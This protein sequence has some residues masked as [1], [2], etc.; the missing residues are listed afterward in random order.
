M[1]R[2]Y[3]RLA[4]TILVFLIAYIV[5]NKFAD[6]PDDKLIAQ[7]ADSPDD[8]LIAQV[9]DSP[10]DK[11]I[12]QVAD[13]LAALEAADGAAERAAD[14][15]ARVASKAGAICRAMHEQRMVLCIIHATD[16]D[17][18]DIAIG[19]V[20]QVQSLRLPLENWILTV[21]NSSDYVVSLS[22]R[23]RPLRGAYSR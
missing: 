8:K 9:A 20:A 3:G 14:K 13:R 16:A 18:E 2:I 11:L 21:V 17:T 7:V 10:D 19:M 1:R 12:A 5:L 15:F 6:S 22:F 4:A 23:D